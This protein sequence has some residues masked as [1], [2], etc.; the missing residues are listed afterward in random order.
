MEL[1]TAKQRAYFQEAYPHLRRALELIPDYYDALLAFG[2]CA[3]YVR[4]F[5]Y[6]VYSY[7]IAGTLNPNDAKAN[8]G[9]WYALQ[10]YGR[11]KLQKADTTRAFEALNQAWQMAKDTSI[12]FTLSRYYAEKN[13]TNLMLEWQEKATWLLPENAAMMMQMAIAY[14]KAGYQAKAK[15]WYQRAKE[16]DPNI[17]DW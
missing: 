5:D 4:Q 3:Y 11:D 2:A 12:A 6:S 16:T 8:T 7:Q 1:D 17:P 9:L 14:R 10:G 13:N 15:E